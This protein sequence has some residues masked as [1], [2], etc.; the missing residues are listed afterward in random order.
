VNT[1]VAEPPGGTSPQTMEAN[2][3]CVRYGGV[4]AVSNVSVGVRAG[5]IV[6]LIGPNGAGK[7]TFIDAIS[8][9][10]RASSGTVRL[11]GERIDTSAAYRRARH[12]L[13]RTFQQLE[14]FTDL[15]VHENL[16]VAASSTRR[17]NQG[18]VD[19]ALDFLELRDMADRQVS[20]LSQ[21]RRRMVALARALASA[22]TVLLLDEPAAGL[23]T[24][25]SEVL[26]ERLRVLAD[27]GMAILLVDHDMGLVLSVCQVVTVM[28]FGEVIAVGTPDE[29]RTS[30]RVLSA[31]LGD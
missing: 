5:E 23:D 4:R 22:P 25:E 26:G 21:G 30:Q 15:T 9:F 24:T 1:S 13:V 11:A 3:I 20:D 17:G 10:V 12:G 18:H 14:L 6:G 2:E 28:D 19:E 29:I 27:Q 16:V 7:T 8:G 31:Y